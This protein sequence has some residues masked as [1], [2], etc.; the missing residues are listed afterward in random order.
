MAVVSVNISDEIAQK[1]E[2]F[3]V[4]QFEDLLSQSTESVSFDFEAEDIDQN[5]F[6]ASLK[7]MNG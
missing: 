4:I 3:Q 5:Q 1:F 6:L 7:S 2:P